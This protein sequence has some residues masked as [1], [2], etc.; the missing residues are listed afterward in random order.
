MESLG[1]ETVSVAGEMNELATGET[2]S[3]GG[4][5]DDV[6]SWRDGDGG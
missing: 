6:G 5:S 1:R 4:W 2:V 3:V